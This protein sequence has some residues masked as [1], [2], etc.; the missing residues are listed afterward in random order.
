M[1][2][3]YLMLTSLIL[4]ILAGCDSLSNFSSDEVWP[5][6][7]IEH[8][9][10][11]YWW[12]MG[13]AVDAENITYNLENLDAAGIGGVTIVPIYGVKGEEDKFINYL[14]PDWMK[15]LEHT[16]QEADRLGMWVDM[17]TGTGWPFGGSH[18]TETYAAKKIESKVI[19][20]EGGKQIV[21]SLSDSGWVLAKAF[22]KQGKTI[23]LSDTINSEKELIWK[24][25][26]GS[27][28]VY[29][30]WQSGTGQKVKRAAP[31][32]QGLVIDPFSVKSLDFYLQRFDEAF[33]K[34]NGPAPRAQYHDSFEYYHANWTDDFLSEFSTRRGYDLT[35]HLPL[36]FGDGEPELTS[37]IKADYRQTLAELHQ[38]YIKNWVDWSHKIG[39]STRDQ[40]HG[41]P[42][43]LLDLYAT[44][45]IPETETFGSTQFAIPGLRR[46]PENIAKDAPNLL[47]LQFSSS[48]A[49]VSGKKLVA[50]ET[51]TWLRDHY[52][53]AL[54]QAKPE[55]DQLFL[56]GINHIFYHG[57][58]YTPAEAEWPGWLFYA[59]THFEKENAIWRDLPALNTYVQRVQSVLQSGE[60]AND[61]LL[62]WPIFD[63]WHDPEGMEQKLT[64]HDNKWLTEQRCGELAH[65]LKSNGYTFDYISDNLLQ[66]AIY[67]NGKITL[68]GGSY[69]TIL[70][71]EC[72]YMP[73]KTWDKLLGL[74]E[75][76]ATILFDNKLPTS[77][78]G[79]SNYIDRQEALSNSMCGLNFDTQTDT[80]T[81]TADL[82]KGRLILGTNEEKLFPFAKVKAE[83]IARKGVGFIRRKHEDGYYY[84]LAN[85][86]DRALDDWVALSQ[87]FVSALILEPISGG[88]G[89]ARV[90]NLKEKSE[91]YLQLQ[92]GESLILK[93][94]TNKK[95]QARSW[96]YFFES[97][98]ETQIG[99][100]WQVDFVDGGPVLPSPYQ[101]DLLVSWTD[102][103]DKECKRFAGTAR[104]ST[105]FNLPNQTSDGWT[106]DLGTVYESARIKIN[107]ENVGILWS[108]PF[109]LVVGKYLKM[110][111][112]RLEIEVTNLSA[113]RIKDLDERKVVWKKF[114]EINFVNINYKKFDASK[115]SLM[116]S[117]LIGPVKLIA[118]KNTPFPQ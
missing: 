103:P 33:E 101:T 37:R 80:E 55:I 29:I 75:S 19:Q 7:K 41:A 13:S 15:M 64:V 45:D 109:R 24:A 110:G 113:N 99:S 34:Y 39:S 85:L 23:D 3:G 47:V 86:S 35:E 89:E 118:G 76:G 107:G 20:V 93:T 40:A 49:H 18:V 63:I 5:D 68:E 25:P 66:G 77:V 21:E 51:C 56:A 72:H 14:N 74:A 43:N 54:S 92:P 70:I 106:L 57:N 27:W 11:V 117:G 46:L 69:Q 22:S 87:P 97:D 114:H 50:S 60:P 28:K 38:K 83:P 91:V 61:I 16:V 58:A 62:Y 115:W 9:P 8:R 79:Y 78:P 65:Y 36:L 44:A 59:S 1:K 81:Y 94:S 100:N 71:P 6:E 90:R 30:L 104:Y 10:G 88:Y 102:F 52:K 17:T 42:G 31:G 111:E 82:G 112:N 32:N 48:A 73:E 96:N 67:K 108:F 53:S 2:H 12:W 84:F 116:P 26:A 105:T 98:Y 4:V 95:Q